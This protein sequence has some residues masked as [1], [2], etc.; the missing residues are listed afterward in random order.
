[1][2]PRPIARLPGAVAVATALA[3]L[4]LNACGGPRRPSLTAQLL[5]A[6]GLVAEGCYRCLDEAVV[7]YVALPPARGA[8]AAANDTKLFRALVFLALREKEL[9]LDSAQH[10]K[11][12]GLLVSKVT[13][14]A[15]ARE[16]LEWAELLLTNTSALPRDVSEAAST[17]LFAARDALMRRLS[18]ASTANDP[19]DVYLNVSLACAPLYQL[20]L[21][22]AND[23]VPP[24]MA[25]S[26]LVQWRLAICNRTHEADLQAF[27]AA[28]PR[29]VEADYWR[30]RFLMALVGQP[31]ARREA[32]ER[33]RAAHTE[34]PG[35]LA[36]AFDLAGVTRVTSPKDA[37]PLYERVTGAQPGHHEAWLGQGICLTYLDRSPEAIA[38]LTKV[39]TLGRWF[40]GE[41]LYWRAWN[42]H[43][44]GDL[45]A[46]WTDV[47]RA[48][49]TLF[50]TDVFGLAGRV[51]HDRGQFDAARPLLKQAI[52]LSNANCQATWFL[53]LVESAQERWLDG[54]R[55]FESAEKCYRTEILRMR[56]E[57]QMASAEV[58]AEVR[59][60]RIAE[61]DAAIKTAEQQA[62]LSAYN[63]AFNY[64][65]GGDTDTSRPLLDRAVLHP[66]VTD[67]ARELR[68]FVNR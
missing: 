42:H 19:L 57:Q 29:Y 35:S 33:L 34:I 59:A 40:T 64:V 38:A 56:E 1:M 39:I 5:V 15:V 2:T 30:G 65:K 45:E 12:A 22:A 61:S 54:G 13:A 48:R 25:A 4:L 3:L 41:A 26:T 66:A 20:K 28:H 23:V 32:R 67:R 31:R 7:R 27:A 62:A 6:D 50:N 16:Q 44:A 8:V 63:A 55:A 53:G 68:A 36:I 37:L 24:A 21:P 11:Q 46:A 58:E 14:P 60:A 51:A 18:T 52:D 47:T 17:R 10:L 9:G 49:S 43:H